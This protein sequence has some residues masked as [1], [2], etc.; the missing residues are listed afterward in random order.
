MIRLNIGCGRRI[1]PGW[2]NVDVEQRATVPE[3]AEYVQ[4]DVR[5][6][7]FPDN[8]ADELMAIHVVEHFYLWEIGAVLAEWHRVLKPRGKLVL[9]CPDILKAALYIIKSATENKQM[10]YQMTMWPLYGDPSHQ[11]PLMCH[12]WGYTPQS[13]IGL[14]TAHGFKFAHE[15][16][17]QFHMKTLRD[18]RVEANKQ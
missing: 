9:E 11:D 14:V 6:L 2:V 4:S 7:P 1:M 15:A 5:K 16:D 18:M 12:K 3:G 10:P 13:L 8:Y 17:A